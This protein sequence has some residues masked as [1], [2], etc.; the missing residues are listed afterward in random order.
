MLSVTSDE[1]DDDTTPPPPNADC[2]SETS[3]ESYDDTTPPP[4]ITLIVTVRLVM[5]VMMT[6][7]H[8]P[9]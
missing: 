6:L 7:H 2:D 5:K 9:L 4:P 8:H 1:S 3:D